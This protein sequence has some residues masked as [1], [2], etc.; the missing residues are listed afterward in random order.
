LKVSSN[1]KSGYTVSY[2]ASGGLSDG[3]N[4]MNNAAVG[5]AGTGGT[6]I[7]AGTETYGVRITPGSITGASGIISTSAAFNAG[8]TNS[9]QYN[10]TTP[11]VILTA[12]KPNSP[13]ASGDT[14]NTSLITHNLGITSNTESG[15]YSQTI[16]YTVAPSF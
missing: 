14:T 3:S 1:A 15:N 10:N 8:A 6:N 13:T 7:V 16:T 9:V 4:T 11:T 5:S 2:Q 12:T